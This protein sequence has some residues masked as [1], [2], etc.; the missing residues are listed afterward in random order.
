MIREFKTATALSRGLWDL[1]MLPLTERIPIYREGMK[2]KAVNL[3]TP[4]EPK[5]QKTSW[6]IRSFC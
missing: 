2:Y 5:H 6:I 4:S 3:V 1:M